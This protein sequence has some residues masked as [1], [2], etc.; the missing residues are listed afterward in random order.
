MI[1][2]LSS[3]GWSSR[4]GFRFRTNIL[5]LA[6][7]A[8]KISMRVQTQLSQ[9]TS[10]YSTAT[11]SSTSAV[12]SVNALGIILDPLLKNS[13]WPV[14][15]Y[16]PMRALC[17]TSKAKLID[18]HFAV[19]ASRGMDTGVDSVGYG[20]SQRAQALALDTSVDGGWCV[21]SVASVEVDTLFYRG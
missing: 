13:K 12:S 14:A 9:W 19:T 20:Q 16:P 15:T 18:F 6:N 10:S 8:K 1:L 4:S 2:I 21:R 7:I 17:C 5:I 11:L 3:R